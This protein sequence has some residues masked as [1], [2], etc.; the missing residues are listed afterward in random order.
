MLLHYKA[1]MTQHARDKH[2]A[3]TPLPWGE[4]F[5][6]ASVLLVT[7][8][9]LLVALA[10]LGVPLLANGIGLTGQGSWHTVFL[11]LVVL[12]SS[13]YLFIQI[14]TDLFDANGNARIL[15]S[16]K[17]QRWKPLTVFAG[18]LLLCV[19]VIFLRLR[20]GGGGASYFGESMPPP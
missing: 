20:G 19:F 4:L 15:V 12:V 7:V 1:L 17:K 2:T 6:D 3:T 13:S 5:Q 9:S 14:V 18:A 11:A 8:V 16:D 10:L